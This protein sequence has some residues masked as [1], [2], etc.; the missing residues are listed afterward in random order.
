MFRARRIFGVDLRSLGLF[1]I[2]LAALLLYDLADRARDLGVFY[3]DDGILPRET[4]LRYFPRLLQACVH[5]ATGSWWGEALIFAV[6]AACAAA[7][8]AGWRTRIASVLCWYLWVS[9][10]CRV[11][12]ILY[13]MDN[14]LRLLLFWGMFLPWGARFS[15]DA[16]RRP[17]AR[18]RESDVF[19]A[20]SAALLVQVAV[21]YWFT[22]AA[23]S[24]PEWTSE[25][26]ALYYT[27]HIDHFVTPL[28]ACLREHRGLCRAL[29]FATLG[30]ESFGPFLFFSP[31]AFL[32]ARLLAV[33]GFAALHVG[34]GACMSVG[35]FPVLGLISLIPFLPAE[36]WELRFRGRARLEAL[37]RAAAARAARI[38]GAGSPFFELPRA[39]DVLVAVLAAYAFAWNL[40]T[41]PPDGMTVPEWAREPGYLLRLDQDWSMFA[42]FPM[43]DNGWF[44]VRGR[45]E[46]GRG[47]DLLHGRPGEP[48]PARPRWIYREYKNKRW[49]KYLMNL[50]ED[51]WAEERQNYA[52]WLCRSYNRARSGRDR[53][54]ELTVK[55][56]MEE[57]KPQGPAPIVEQT[58][59]RYYCY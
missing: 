23:K 26:S 39:L 3:T 8:L 47:V 57:I 44:V 43:K 59:V 20:A 40:M 1:R 32:P 4:A 28:G 37:A 7:L 38:P 36:A 25:G 24:A 33:A 22:A 6:M 55:Y 54:R 48:D 12:P 18:P 46:D 27:L 58:F 29:T 41:P 56:M 2:A 16:A 11:P 35:L 50:R 14:L 49:K 34:I 30:W 15:V 45:L 31:V 52:E 21:M 9:L 13:G 42:P 10:Q 19:S 17:G 5:L 51:R 53:L